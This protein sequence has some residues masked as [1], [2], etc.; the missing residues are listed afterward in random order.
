MVDKNSSTPLYQQIQTTLLD[1]IRSGEFSPGSQ[2]LSELE[3]AD[4]YQVSR[5]TA[6]K[7][8]DTLVSKGVLYRQRG[9]GTYVAENVVS[10]GLSSM[11]SF[12]QT[13]KAQGFNVETRVLMKEILP[14]PFDVAARLQIDSTA[15]MIVIRRLRHIEGIPCAIH[16]SYFDHRMFAALM[17]RDLN[18]ESLLDVAQT[19]TGVRV[20]YSNDAVMADLAIGEEAKLLN[21]PQNSPVLRV[22]GVAYSEHGQPTRF[23]RAVYRGDMFRLMVKNT[24]DIAASFQVTDVGT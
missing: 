18:T 10:Y 15:P 21:I 3:I 13:L 19:I 24:A 16:A 9:K 11:L 7:A 17:E 8:I 4:K 2:I 6:R 12:S 14:A 22:E 23:I 5:M 1:A 20:A